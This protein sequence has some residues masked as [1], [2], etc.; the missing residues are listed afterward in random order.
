MG[1]LVAQPEQNDTLWHTMSL[2]VQDGSAGER[3][4]STN[5]E[6]QNE[7]EERKLSLPVA[8]LFFLVVIFLIFTFLLRLLLCRRITTGADLRRHDVVAALTALPS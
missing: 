3:D 1:G 2:R 4:R 8:I 6:R 7:M 5:P